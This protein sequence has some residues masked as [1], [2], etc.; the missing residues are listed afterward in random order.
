MGE[1]TDLNGSSLFIK[2]EI[3]E[4]KKAVIQYLEKSIDEN[5]IGQSIENIQILRKKI[6]ER[7]N[8]LPHEYYLAKVIE[9]LT[10][11]KKIGKKSIVKWNPR[12]TGTGDEPDI[13]IVNNG[14]VTYSCELTTSIEA[15]GKIDQRM[16]EVLEKLSK[17]EGEKVYIVVSTNMKDRAET[18]IRN[19]NY[20][21]EVLDISR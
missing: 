19:V 7:M 17:M 1:I 8:Q 21:I 10:N 18:K 14:I 16:K 11:E 9:K 12:Q 15:K 3:I 6:Y 4:L 13:Q 5:S 2:S 20:D